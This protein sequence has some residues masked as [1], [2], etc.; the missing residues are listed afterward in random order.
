L[1][2]PI[3]ACWQDPYKAISW[4]ALPVPNKYRSGCS[5]PS[6]GLS[7]GSLM[8]ELEKV[9]K[10]LRAELFLNLIGGT[11][12]WTNQYFQSSLGLTTSQRKYMVKL[13]PLAAYVAEDGL[14]GHQWR[15]RPW[16]L[17]RI[18]APL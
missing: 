1:W 7:T 18:Y 16:V 4:E 6:I 2:M 15:E 11:T 9:P 10:D 17:W 5:Q 8:K 14:V 13:M 12:I 3:S